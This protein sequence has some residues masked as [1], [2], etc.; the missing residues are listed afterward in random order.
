[1][2]LR[3]RQLNTVVGTVGRARVSVSRSGGKER[4]P[5]RMRE[6]QRDKSMKTESMREGGAIERKRY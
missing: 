1:M 6:R 2:S 3:V 5:E 4:M